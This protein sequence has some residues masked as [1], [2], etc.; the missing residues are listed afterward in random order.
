MHDGSNAIA[1]C[2]IPQVRVNI[3]HRNTAS[4]I[5]YTNTSKNIVTSLLTEVIG[6][7]ARAI[8][9]VRGVRASFRPANIFMPIVGIQRVSRRR[10]ASRESAIIDM[11]I[12]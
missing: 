12:G 6:D 9:A 2:I 7:S 8:H 5:F 4:D 3:P 10:I 11:I 1:A